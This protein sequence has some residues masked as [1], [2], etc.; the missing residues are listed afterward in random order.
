[1]QNGSN[2]LPA[3]DAAIAANAML[4]LTEPGK[5]TV[6]I[7]K[8]VRGAQPYARFKEAIDSLLASGNP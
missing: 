7:L 8:I 1:M 3:V 5:G 6:K 4:G 2:K